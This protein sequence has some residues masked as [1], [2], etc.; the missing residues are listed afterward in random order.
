MKNRVLLDHAESVVS[1]LWIY[2]HIWD[3][4]KCGSGSISGFIWIWHEKCIL[5][6]T[7]GQSEMS[8]WGTAAE[9]SYI[10]CVDKGEILS[11]LGLS[12]ALFCALNALYLPSRETTMV[13]Q[14]FYLLFS[15]APSSQCDTDFAT[16]SCQFILWVFRNILH[17]EIGL[18]SDTVF[19]SSLFD[20]I[21]QMD[22]KTVRRECNLF[23]FKLDWSSFRFTR[24]A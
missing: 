9:V 15:E 4:Y 5:K 24:A 8:M 3:S 16:Q 1:H 7:Q 13:P 10:M 6:T 18:S 19:N 23:T 21:I 14:R 22:E 12:T 11:A 20:F 17:I 2:V